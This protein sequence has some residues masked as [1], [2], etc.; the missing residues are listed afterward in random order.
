M[1]RAKTSGRADDTE[2]IIEK[3]LL[4]Y[5]NQSRPVV[6]MYRQFGIV[7]EVDGSGS[8]YDV[9]NMTRKAM[10]PQISFVIG[11]KNPEDIGGRLA[12]RTHAK[13]IDF[14][15]FVIEHELE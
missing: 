10:L 13:M 15:S 14:P 5:E 11:P 9:W 4:T 2:E 1:E 6:E 12:A 8:V 7:R 3:R